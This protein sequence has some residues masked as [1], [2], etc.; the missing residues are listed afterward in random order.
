[1]I[2]F[3]DYTSK[4]IKTYINEEKKIVVTIIEIYVTVPGDE[5]VLF[6]KFIGKAKCM[7]EDKFDAKIGTKISKDRAWIKY[8]NACIKII[9]KEMDET[10]DFVNV[11]GGKLLKYMHYSQSARDEITSLV[12]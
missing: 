9:N 11:L 12:K 5:P 3:L 10:D 8:N 4:R 1:M 2:E 7:N 6:R